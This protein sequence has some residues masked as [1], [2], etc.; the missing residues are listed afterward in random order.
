KCQVIVSNSTH[1]SHPCCG[2]YRCPNPLQDNRHRFCQE[3]FNQHDVCA[4]TECTQPIQA[5][6]KTCSTP[7]HQ[8]MEK[9][10]VEKGKA[11]FPLT[12]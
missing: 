11:A 10:H 2:V 12:E 9:L 8:K 5:G 3:H 6:T 1:L 4:I 7:A